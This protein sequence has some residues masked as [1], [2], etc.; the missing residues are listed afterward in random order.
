MCRSRQP[1]QLCWWRGLQS[2]LCSKQSSW[3]FLTEIWIILLLFLSGVGLGRL[4]KPP[5]FRVVLARC[6]SW[7]LIGRWDGK[8]CQR[9]WCEAVG[10]L[11]WGTP[12]LRAVIGCWPGRVALQWAEF[13]L[14]DLAAG[15]A[16]SAWR[17]AELLLAGR[18]AFLLLLLLDFWCLGGWEEAPEGS[19]KMAGVGAGEASVAGRR[20]AGGAGATTQFTRLS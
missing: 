7:I 20:D 6:G 17:D 8:L 5:D 3:G 2:H 19:I 1:R 13:S 14:A 15:V 11:H 12:H 9:R 4:I 10:M 18:A 16:R